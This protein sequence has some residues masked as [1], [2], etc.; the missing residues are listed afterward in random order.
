MGF[1]LNRNITEYKWLGNGQGIPLLQINEEGPLVTATY[2]DIY[3]MSTGPLSVTLGPDTTVMHETTITLTAD[4]S[5]G[6]PPYRYLWST[7]DTLKSITVTVTD[8]QTYTVFV[9]DAQ[10]NF[11][12]AQKKISVSYPVGETEIS[13]KT[14]G[15]YPNPSYGPVTVS[16]PAISRPAFLKVIN[17]LGR[18]VKLQEILQSE[19]PNTLDLSDLS[20]GIYIL[21]ISNSEQIYTKKLIIRN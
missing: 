14:V 1:P 18:I 19:N 15:V 4:V 3:R 10:Q 20:A 11:G 13:N 17:P 2:R 12:F 5:G 21:Q 9:Y 16:L 8:P 6:V 7:L